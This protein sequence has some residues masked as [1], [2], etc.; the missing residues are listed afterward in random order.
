MNKADRGV[1]RERI[2][3]G[4]RWDALPW[5]Q[6]IDCVEGYTPARPLSDELPGADAP[7]APLGQDLN[8]HD[9]R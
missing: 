1:R 9:G 3:Q 6:R 7:S 2:A 5:T 8:F 4:D